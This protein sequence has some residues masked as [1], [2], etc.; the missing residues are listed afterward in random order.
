MPLFISEIQTTQLTVSI[1]SHAVNERVQLVTFYG[2]M[3]V[4]G[5][6]ETFN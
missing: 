5:L 1:I 3:Q 6:K 4:S 2:H